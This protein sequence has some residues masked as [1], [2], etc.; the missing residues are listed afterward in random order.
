MSGRVLQEG[1]GS[2]VEETEL[3]I[4]ITCTAPRY[5]NGDLGVEMRANLETLTLRPFYNL[6]KSSG[7]THWEGGWV[8]SGLD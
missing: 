2:R 3:C 4:V 5:H 1:W 8:A 6:Q 7:G